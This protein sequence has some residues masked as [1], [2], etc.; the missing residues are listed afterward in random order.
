VGQAV[1]DTSIGYSIVIN[2]LPLN[3]S[4]FE[5]QSAPNSSSKLVNITA[6]PYKL[7]YRAAHD[8][9]DDVDDVSH[10]H[11]LPPSSATVRGRQVVY[12]PRSLVF[13][14]TAPVDVFAVHALRDDGVR[15]RAVNHVGACSCEVCCCDAT[16][17]HT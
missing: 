16:L 15:S 3:G 1:E 4:L 5:L 10:Q 8:C 11:V 17:A 6:V 13:H 12:L 2:S 14:D 7:R 9:M